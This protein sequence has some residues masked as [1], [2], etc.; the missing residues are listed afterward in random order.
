MAAA[1]LQRWAVQL[2]AYTYDLEYRTTQNHSNADG[3][4]RLPLKMTNAEDCSMEANP[5]K[6]AE[7]FNVS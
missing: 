4:S 1:R 2:S 6:E 3:L 7:V 5:A